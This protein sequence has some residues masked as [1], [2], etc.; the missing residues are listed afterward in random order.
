M[1]H[2][3]SKQHLFFLLALCVAVFMF[4]VAFTAEA[5]GLIP[6]GGAGEPLCTFNFFIQLIRNVINFLLVSIAI[7]LAMILFAY[8]GWLYMSAGGDPGKIS[9]GHQ[10]FRNVVVGLVLALAAW[11]I[12]NTIANALLDRPLFNRNFFFLQQTLADY[13]VFSG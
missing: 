6:C 3:S 9:Q 10:I 1:K 13:E 4:G 7:P 12:V 2:I 8:A 5:R 11:L